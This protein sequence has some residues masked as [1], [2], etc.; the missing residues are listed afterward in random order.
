MVADCLFLSDFFQDI[1][2]QEWEAM[3]YH[4]KNVHQDV[5]SKKP[6]QNL[7]DGFQE[8]HHQKEIETKNQ[9]RLSAL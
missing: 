2:G 5:K 3:F 4:C 6:A 1:E 7:G 9:I 8:S